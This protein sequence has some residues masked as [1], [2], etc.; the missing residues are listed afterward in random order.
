MQMLILNR[1][2]IG[3]YCLI[4]GIILFV[5]GVIGILDIIKT[6][7]D[8]NKLTS[9]QI[10][11][12]VM[13]EG[14]IKFNFGKY[15]YATRGNSDY[16]TEDFFVIALKDKKLIGY[17]VKNQKVYSEMMDQSKETMNVLKDRKLP[18]QK[19][20]F[21]GKVIKAFDGEPDIIK[22]Y[23]NKFGIQEL[24]GYGYVD[25]YVIK[26]FDATRQYIYFGSGILLLIIGII[27]EIIEK[28][29]RPKGTKIYRSPNT[30]EFGIPKR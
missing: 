7:I 12:G 1:L 24:D 25:D 15:G 29:N 6:P 30:T 21:K 14:D 3:I 9:D 20:H 23:L 17:H 5:L 2:W 19:I 16:P 28:K 8:Y 18:S 27:L 26:E 11:K 22:S 4:G 10:E 13:V